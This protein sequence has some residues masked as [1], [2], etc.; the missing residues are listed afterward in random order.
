M[1]IATSDQ[2]VI[3]SNDEDH[4]CGAS[5]VRWISDP[6]GLTQFGAFEEILAPG[7]RSSLKHW[8]LTQDELVYVLSGDVTVVEG[9]KVTILRPGDAATFP[10]NVV[11]GHC[12]ENRSVEPCRYIVVGTPRKP[13]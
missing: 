2:M 7:S 10:A 6:G 3:E 11:V 12:L 9:E 8:H 1:P 5:K 4:P 13:T